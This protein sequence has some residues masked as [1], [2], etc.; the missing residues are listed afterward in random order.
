M[1]AS[2][3]KHHPAGQQSNFKIGLNVNNKSQVCLRSFHPYMHTCVHRYTYMP[4]IT[5]HYIASHHIPLHYIT[6]HSITLHTR[7]IYLYPSM[8]KHQ[9]EVAKTLHNINSF[10]NPIGLSSQ[11]PTG[12]KNGG[13][14]Q[15]MTISRFE[16][17]H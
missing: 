4:V 8:L 9:V 17:N 13:H 1:T 3:R 12:G 16:A 10:G 11:P 14:Y 2:Q 5:L 15:I 7:N 6:S